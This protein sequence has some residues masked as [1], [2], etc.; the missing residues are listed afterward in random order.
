[1]GHRH[2]CIAFTDS[3]AKQLEE[4]SENAVHALD[5]SLVAISVDQEI[6]DLHT[7][8]APSPALRQYADE[9]E[10]VRVLYFITALLTVVVVA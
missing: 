8:P 7:A 9:I 6:G 1:M 3:A 10:D 2:A 4:L 5:S